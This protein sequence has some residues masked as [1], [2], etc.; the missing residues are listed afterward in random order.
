MKTSFSEELEKLTARLSRFGAV[1]DESMD[2][3][4]MI[5]FRLGIDRQ[6]WTQF[7]EACNVQAGR[8]LSPAAVETRAFYM[9]PDAIDAVIE[10][11]NV[12]ENQGSVVLMIWVN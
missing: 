8:E 9:W 7:A 4:S 12:K 11:Y 3:E 5:E 2:D 10:H 6:R 1:D